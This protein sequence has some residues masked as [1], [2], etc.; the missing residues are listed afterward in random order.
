MAPTSAIRI[1][2]HG[3]CTHLKRDESAG[4]GKLPTP[5]R[6]LLVDSE[7]GMVLDGQNIPKHV[8]ILRIPKDAVC[9][10]EK[11]LFP[12]GVAPHDDGHCYWWKLGK[13]G[14]KVLAGDPTHG[15]GYSYR[16][17]TAMPRI[18]AFIP[19]FRVLP[20]IVVETRKHI[21]ALVDVDAGVFDVICRKEASGALLT[22]PTAGEKGRLEIWR[23]DDT[24]N[25]STICLEA[26]AYVLVEHAEESPVSPPAAPGQPSPE[27]P[28][29]LLHYL[30]G[31][32]ERIPHHA[33]VYSTP[34][35]DTN[36]PPPC[37]GDGAGLGAFCSNTD[38][39]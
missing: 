30:V 22:I 7:E 31:G 1:E 38:Y 17:A 2:F 11:P 16:W 36:D 19:G 14:M 5:H 29:F 32:K 27:G 10:G 20:E 4:T 33:P 9:E 13:H 12:G 3:I 24:G 8:P 6:V 28:H 26:N 18:R 15:V 39:P 34:C 35:R 21:A 23:L 37:S 25:R